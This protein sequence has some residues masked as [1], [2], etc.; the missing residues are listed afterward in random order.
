MRQSRLLGGS[1]RRTGASRQLLLAL[2]LV[3]A[4]SILA[5]IANLPSPTPYSPY[6]TGSNGYSRLVREVNVRIIGSPVEVEADSPSNITVLVPLTR[7]L[8]QASASVLQELLARGA[9]VVVLDE[10][11]Y[12]NSLLEALGIKARVECWKVL[13]EVSKLG[14]RAHPLVRVWLRG[15]TSPML[16]A[17]YL[18]SYITLS[19]SRGLVGQGYTSSYAYADL[20]GNMYF[21]G[22]D[23]MGSYT[24]VAAWRIEGGTLAVIADLDALS[25]ALFSNADNSRL[26]QSLV[27]SG[28]LV[29]ALE[30]IN[31]TWFDSLKLAFEK[32]SLGSRGG[33]Q[34]LG[35]L[36]F[37]LLALLL[38]VV[39]YAGR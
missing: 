29:L 34:S 25:N 1:S 11:G 3:L 12:S 19:T 17:T 36:E 9:T 23:R 30:Y 33:L 7:E 32:A 21:S 6:N 37:A 16:L 39:R 38:V 4:V 5:I 8:D 18:P 24:I 27:G 35:V 14:D 20:D 10:N 15:E 22:T 26:L 31:H 13:D 28:R 2:A